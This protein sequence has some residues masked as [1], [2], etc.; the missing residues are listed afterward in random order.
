MAVHAAQNNNKASS[1]RSL[2]QTA[3]RTRKEEFHPNNHLGIA[4][5]YP[6]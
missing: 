1:T 6:C 2:I 3:F 5:T 4:R